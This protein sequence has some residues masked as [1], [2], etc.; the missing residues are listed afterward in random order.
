M[1]TLVDDD[2]TAWRHYVMR[3]PAA[4]PECTSLRQKFDDDIS[5]Q[6][7]VAKARAGFGKTLASAASDPKTSLFR[8][9]ISDALHE[10]D[11]AANACRFYEC[12]G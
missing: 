6:E 4:G 9:R 1:P 12:L 8:L 3:V 10:F 7:L 5:R 11:S 2:A